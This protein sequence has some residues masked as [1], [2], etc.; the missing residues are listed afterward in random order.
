[1]TKAI[2]DEI[3]KQ[4]EE[5]LDDDNEIEGLVSEAEDETIDSTYLIKVIQI[6]IENESE[7]GFRFEMDLPNPYANNDLKNLCGTY[8]QMGFRSEWPAQM[9]KANITNTSSGLCD[10]MKIRWWD[11]QHPYAWDP[12][13]GYAGEKTLKSGGDE[14]GWLYACPDHTSQG[15]MAFCNAPRKEKNRSKVSITAITH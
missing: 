2:L 4:A 6:N 14:T 7:L 15:T 12:S 8:K 3:A 11:Q 10:G 9:V 5:I 13:S 1:M